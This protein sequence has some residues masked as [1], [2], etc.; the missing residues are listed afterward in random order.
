[1][2][3]QQELPVP[4]VAL[5]QAQPELRQQALLAL[6]GRLAAHLQISSVAPNS[7]AA[8][9]DSLAF[10]ALPLEVVLEH[11]L[12]LLPLALPVHPQVLVAW[13]AE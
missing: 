10:Q 5:P 11:L 2:A 12:E 4:Q 3:E 6:Q 1:L 9:L 13:L 8:A 7:L